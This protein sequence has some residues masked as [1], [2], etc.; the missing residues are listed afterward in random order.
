VYVRLAADWADPTGAVHG[1]GEFVDVDVVT[2]AEL[3]EQGVVENPEEV[4]RPEWIGPGKVEDVTE[5]WIGPGDEIEAP[6]DADAPDAD[7]EV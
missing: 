2:L 1:A 6:D 5:A 7:E 4:G 3:E